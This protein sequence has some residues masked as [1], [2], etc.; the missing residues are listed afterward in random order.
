MAVN[1]TTALTPVELRTG[2]WYK[3]EDYHRLGPVNGAKLR[4]CQALIGGMASRGLQNVVTAASVLSPQHAIVASVAAS[5]GMISHHIVGATND[6]ALLKHPST[7]AALAQGAKFHHIGCA[8]NASLQ[9]AADRLAEK[10]PSAEV[11]HYGITTAERSSRHTVR[12]FA[13]VGGHQV[14]NLPAEVRTL[15]IPFGS[16][17]SACGV[18]TGLSM[19][20]R[21]DLAVKLVGIGPPRL[22]WL[23]E[24]LTRINVPIPPDI[25]LFDLHSSGYAKYSDKMPETRDGITFH[26]TYEGKVVRYLDHRR[27]RWW[28]DRDG[29][30]AM[31][32]VGAPVQ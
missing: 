12:A 18:L 21:M 5:L 17:N 19:Y 1:V 3:R 29:T 7:K 30:T 11:M 6:A 2:R 10:L 13:E 24:R 23:F 32:I 15:V 9:P 28:T 27:P 8:Y 26:P 20:D 14:A 16:G 4:A 25:E 22:T 31:W